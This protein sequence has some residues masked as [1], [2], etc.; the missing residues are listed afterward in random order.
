[1]KFP[2]LVEIVQDELIFETG[3]LL[4]GQV[5]PNNSLKQLTP[6]TKSGRHFPLRRWLY[7]LAPLY[8]KVEALPFRF[9]NRH[10]NRTLCLACGNTD[11]QPNRYVGTHGNYWLGIACEPWLY[12]KDPSRADG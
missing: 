7:S 4:A 8:R 10:A 1:M 12:W 9:A 2:W 11:P 6:W 5:E 3:L